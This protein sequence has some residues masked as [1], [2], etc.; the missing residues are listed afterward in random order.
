MTKIG[1]MLVALAVAIVLG[2]ASVLLFWSS[3]DR[4]EL[5]ILKDSARSQ[6]D[7]GIATTNGNEGASEKIPSESGADANMTFEKIKMEAERGS[8]KA[9]R[10][11][12]EIYALCAGYSL[13]PKKQLATLD[14]LSVLVP[15]S[16]SGIDGV[17][18]R[19]VARCGGVDFGQPIPMEAVDL[20]VEQAAKGG[21]I[22]SR[23]KIR[24][25]STQPLLAEEVNELLE[26]VLTSGDPEALLEMSSLMSRPVVGELSGRY[27]QLAGDSTI[28]A[29]WGVAACRVGASC[30]SD[31]MLMDSICM[32]TGKCSYRT[33]EEFLASEVVS[34]A[35]RARMSFVASNILRLSDN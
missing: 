27:Q 35:E 14:N 10:K 29:A 31:S 33:Y 19:L 22:A 34:P 21:D 3:G 4:A 9:Q 12:S 24:T 17:K 25:R 18:Q 28:G 20:W 8:A 16:K 6:S 7:S 30:G 2:V 15:A 23:I 32:S 26:D 11:L 13:D 1:K 5:G